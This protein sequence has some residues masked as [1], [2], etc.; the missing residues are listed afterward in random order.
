MSAPMRGMELM[1]SHAAAILL[2]AVSLYVVDD[3]G[4]AW[5]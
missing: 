3:T 1:R 5:R 2:A 4:T